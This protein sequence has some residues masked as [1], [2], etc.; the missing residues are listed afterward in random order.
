MHARLALVKEQLIN[1]LKADSH[2]GKRERRTTKA[3]FKA[4]RALG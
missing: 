3:L 2:R 1:C 4:I